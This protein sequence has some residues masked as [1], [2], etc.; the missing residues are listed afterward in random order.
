MKRYV[1][2]FVLFILAV[3]MLFFTFPII[4]VY[5]ANKCY[6]EI[7]EKGSYGPYKLNYFYILDIDRDKTPELICMNQWFDNSLYVFSVK[8]GKLVYLGTSGSKIGFKEIPKLYY[9]KKYKS[10]CC[11]EKDA[12]YGGGLSGPSYT[13]YRINGKKIKSWKY[14]AVMK[15][16]SAKYYANGTASHKYKFVS[17]KTQKKFYKKYFS[18]K[19]L[20]SYKLMENTPENRAKF[21]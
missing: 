11:Q 13:Y 14:T 10:L 9:S 12:L 7:L 6:K 16:G 1:K 21:F 8:K 2:I 5:A 15:S 20:K 4:T 18:P 3:N 19:Y 17:K